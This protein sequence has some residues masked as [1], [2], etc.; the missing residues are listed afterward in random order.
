MATKDFDA[1][2]AERAGK[3]PTFKVGGQEFTARAKLPYKRFQK[4]MATMTADDTDVDEG[5]EMFFRSVIIP[6]D[7]DRFLALLNNEDDDDN[8]DSVVDAYQLNQITEWLLGIYT[9]KAETSSSSSSDGSATTG[10]SRN[11]VSL[12]SRA[13]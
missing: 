13:G 7:R 12:N 4:I 2:L 6:A 9:G 8:E 3:R 11:V 1:M 5:T 10:V